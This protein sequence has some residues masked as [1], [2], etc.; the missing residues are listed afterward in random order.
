MVGSAVA[1]LLA[2]V[3]SNSYLWYTMRKINQFRVFPHLWRPIGAGILM[4]IATWLMAT[5]G[6][7]IVLNIAIS[8]IVYV[9]ALFFL[10]EPL[11]SEIKKVLALRMA[12]A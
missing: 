1:T 11:F 9:A 3:L 12:E 8:G 4:A 10:G 7:E 6:T 5:M 2:Q